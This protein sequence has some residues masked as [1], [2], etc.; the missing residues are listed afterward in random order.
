MGHSSGHGRLTKLGRRP[1]ATDSTPP[2]ARQDQF[3]VAEVPDLFGRTL[4]AAREL[5]GGNFAVTAEPEETPLTGLGVI[6]EQRPTPEQWAIKG[7]AI[8]VWLSNYP[9]S[10]GAREPRTPLPRPLRVSSARQTPDTEA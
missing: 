7:S 10:G 4:Q 9:P 8:T 1:E 5:I 6:V 3:D 2:A